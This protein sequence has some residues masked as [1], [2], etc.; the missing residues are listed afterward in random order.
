MYVRN[1]V[2]SCLLIEYKLQHNTECLFIKIN[3][4]KKNWLFCC[5][6]N[7]NKNNILKHLHCLSKGLDANISQYDNIMFLEDPNVEGSDPVLNDFCNVYNLFSP[8]KG[9]ICLKNL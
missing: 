8:V 9:P 4:R 3:I 5:S 6:Y 2:S 7:P 1:D